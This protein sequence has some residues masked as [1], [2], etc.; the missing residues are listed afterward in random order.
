MRLRISAGARQGG[1]ARRLKLSALSYRKGESTEGVS[2]VSSVSG[3]EFRRAML[4]ARTGSWGP[5]AK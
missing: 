3:S 1:L 5:C 2:Q 4:T